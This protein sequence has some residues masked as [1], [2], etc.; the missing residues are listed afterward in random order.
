MP[1]ASGSASPSR[2]WPTSRT[3]TTSS[4]YCRVA[5]SSSDAWRM[6]HGNWPSR[7]C[8]RQ[9]SA[10]ACSR[11]KSARSQRFST[12]ALAELLQS[13]TIG[14]LRTRYATAAAT[15]ARLGS[16]YGSKHPALIAA[17]A[18]LVEAQEQIDAQ[19]SRVIEGL[20]ND[21]AAATRQQT[22]LETELSTLKEQSK[23][24]EQFNVQLAALTREA[25]AD[26]A[27]FNQYLGR[28]KETNQEQTLRFDNARIVSPALPPLKPSRPGTVHPPAGCGALRSHAQR[29]CCGVLRECP[30]RLAY[31]GG[32]G[33]KPRRAVPRHRSQFAGALIGAAP[34]CGRVEL[35][36]T[37]A[38]AQR[39]GHCHPSQAIG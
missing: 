25:E 20:R 8:A 39:V 14:S 36:L 3:P 26:R 32:C 15:V 27:L 34:G 38:R 31:V 1:S 19:I 33:G 24:Q 30:L 6:F 21:Y 13:Q 7:S 5:G 18:Q 28:L 12:D 10:G 9:R 22:A 4:T 2:R 11:S 37:G 35:Q 16:Q 29:R 17:R 23:G